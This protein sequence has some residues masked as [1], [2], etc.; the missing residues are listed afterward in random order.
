MEA[1]SSGLAQPLSE[2]GHL[3]SPLHKNKKKPLLNKAPNYKKKKKKRF[4]VS[5][6]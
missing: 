5:P 3:L 6:I 1:L 2:L 4:T